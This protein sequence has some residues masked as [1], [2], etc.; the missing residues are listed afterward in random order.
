[1]RAGVL[2]WSLVFI[3]AAIGGVV[4]SGRVPDGT[5]N[6][7]AAVQPSAVSLRVE[8]IATPSSGQ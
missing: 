5:S 1:M 7:Q 6:L 4:K 8:R 3:A 2:A